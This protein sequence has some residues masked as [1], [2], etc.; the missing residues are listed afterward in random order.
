MRKAGR[1]CPGAVPFDGDKIRVSAVSIRGQKLFSNLSLELELLPSINDPH[2]Q[3]IRC[4]ATEA[5]LVVTGLQGHDAG[6]R[7]ILHDGRRAAGDQTTVSQVAE[8][9]GSLI[10]DTF[11]SEVGA[12][13][14][15]GEGFAG[16]TPQGAVGIRNRVA[17]GIAVGVSQVLVDPVDQAF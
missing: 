17:V 15:A 2:Q 7:E 10:E 11:E 6:G 4:I 16:S 3:L 14:T 8:K 9:F 12:C 1:F 5:D 13:L